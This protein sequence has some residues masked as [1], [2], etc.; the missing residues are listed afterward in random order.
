LSGNPHSPVSDLL[1]DIFC[2]LPFDAELAALV[3]FILYCNSLNDSE[4]IVGIIIFFS[5]VLDILADAVTFSYHYN[6]LWHNNPGNLWFYNFSMPIISS[7][8]A[9][10]YYTVTANSKM[11]KLIF[12]G[13]LLFI[14]LH[15]LNLRYVQ[16]NGSLGSYSILFGQLFIGAIAFL[17]LKNF[18]EGTDQSPFKNFIFW[19]S[20]ATLISNFV[21]A[22]VTSLLAWFA[23]QGSEYDGAAAYFD[24]GLSISYYLNYCIV[25]I[26]LLWTR[27]NQTSYSS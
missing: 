12:Y 11:R 8:Y 19:F 14:V 18:V 15:I 27:R 16:V 7:M 2:W 17:Y 6:L 10:L 26:G 13:F 21:T 22:P 4:M 5:W 3:V 9:F 25:I 24:F 23:R 20:M 1:K